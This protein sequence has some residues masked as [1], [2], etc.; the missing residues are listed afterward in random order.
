[1]SA[2]LDLQVACENEQLPTAD[3][4]QL[5][6]DAALDGAD[7]PG[8][9]ITIRLVNRKESQQLNHQYR[10]R[11]SSTNVLSFPFEAP[12]GIQM[13]LL[14]DL[15]I[16]AQVVEQESQQQN[17]PVMHHWAHMT[18][19]GTLHLLGY[20]H[21]DDKDAERMEALE[22]AILAKLAIDDPYQDRE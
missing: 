17:K 14:G 12:A 3:H 13:D 8:A 19:H 22:I 4:F 15:V 9:E 11:D 5:W 20:D 6:L 2:L 1:M 16:C 21:I 7:H 18:I 10:N